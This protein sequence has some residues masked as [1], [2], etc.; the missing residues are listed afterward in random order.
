MCCYFFWETPTHLE[1]FQTNLY[2]GQKITTASWH[3]D[4]PWLQQVA[5]WQRRDRRLR[6]PHVVSSA[7]LS[8]I[9]SPHQFTGIQS[10]IVGVRAQERPCW[11]EQWEPEAAERLRAVSWPW[12]GDCSS[13]LIWNANRP[14]NSSTFYLFW[15]QALLLSFFK[16]HLLYLSYESSQLLSHTCPCPVAAA[17]QLKVVKAL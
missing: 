13:L 17:Q 2:Q 15:L 7:R 1:H 5:V 6:D 11:M 14:W 8:A 12:Q 16:S 10:A 9:V 3:N 4:S